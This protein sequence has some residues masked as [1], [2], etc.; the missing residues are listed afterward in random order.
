[1]F[2]AEVAD[3]VIS[4]ETESYRCSIAAI[5]NWVTTDPLTHANEPNPS[6]ED[7]V[8]VDMEHLRATASFEPGL[9]ASYHIYPYY[10]DFFSF[11]EDSSVTDTYAQYL[12]ELNA[13]HT[14][15]V[16]VAEVASPHQG[17]RAR[18]RTVGLQSGAMST[19]RSRVRSC[20][21]S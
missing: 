5:N 8:S 13:H 14:M 17:H 15:P 19:K 18:Q 12:S 4:Y 2:L 21:I 6:V 9:F 20:P 3:R 10:P 16:L 7:A 1:M 11:P